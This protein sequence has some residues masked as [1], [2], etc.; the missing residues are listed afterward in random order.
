MLHFETFQ[1]PCKGLKRSIRDHEISSKREVR[2]CLCLG[3]AQVGPSKIRLVRVFVISLVRKARIGSK[4]Y[5]TALETTL[6]RYTVSK[7]L[8]RGC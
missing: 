6:N 3:K 7:T 1:H 2:P 5:L 8:G 4:N